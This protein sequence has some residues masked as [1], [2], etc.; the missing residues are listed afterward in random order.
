MK[1]GKIDI[2]DPYKQMID[3]AFG[4]AAGSDSGRHDDA[5]HG[6]IR[7]NSAR[8][9]LEGFIN[10]TWSEIV[11]DYV[12]GGGKNL[13]P[14]DGNVTRQALQNIMSQLFST[15]EGG[16]FVQYGKGY[17]KNNINGDTLT[18]ISSLKPLPT[19]DKDP[20][21]YIELLALNASNITPLGLREDRGSNF[22][23]CRA[24]TTPSKS[25][26]GGF[27]IDFAKY[28]RFSEGPTATLVSQNGTGGEILVASQA[29]KINRYW[30]KSAGTGYTVGDTISISPGKLFKENA[31][32]ASGFGA[33]LKVK[34]VDGTTRG[35]TSVEIVEPGQD[36]PPHNRYNYIYDTVSGIGGI[37]DGTDGCGH[38]H[39]YGPTLFYHVHM[40]P[41]WST[42][43]T[44]NPR[45]ELD[46]QNNLDPNLMNNT[47]PNYGVFQIVMDAKFLQEG[48]M[49][50]RY[51]VTA[52]KFKEYSNL[53]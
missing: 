34:T 25:I 16:V 29:G 40:V 36:Y 7:Y 49:S 43:P 12:I 14:N 33:V 47:D 50:G 46:R 32:V 3:T 17:Y 24:N 37:M 10:N 8:K 45:S 30:I 9:V 11:S 41:A 18:D 4:L 5:E 51:L 35:I 22:I 38:Y 20:L 27:K 2:S 13:D 44:N 42:S 52:Y 21:G 48:S 39:H 26:T 1:T 6:M 31:Y 15:S 28:F 53:Q 23:Y 19:I